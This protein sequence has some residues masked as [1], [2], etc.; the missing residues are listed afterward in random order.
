[1]AGIPLHI[2]T[3]SDATHKAFTRVSCFLK[4]NTMLTH[5]TALIDVKFGTVGYLRISWDVEALLIAEGSYKGTSGQVFLWGASAVMEPNAWHWISAVLGSTGS[6][7]ELRLNAQV[8]RPDGTTPGVQNWNTAAHVSQES[9]NAQ[10]GWGVPVSS[11]HNPFPNAAG[12]QMTELVVESKLGDLAAYGGTMPGPRTPPIA[13]LSVGGDIVALYHCGV[14]LGANQTINDSGPGGY[15]LS[16]GPNGDLI[17][18]DA[19]F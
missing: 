15:D 11:T 8:W 3:A 14:A 4:V 17:L 19:P 6:V 16:P 2:G 10:L 7:N 9:V 13:P 5:Q 12:D 18:H 1:M